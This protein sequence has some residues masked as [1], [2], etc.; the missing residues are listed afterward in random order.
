[1]YT[2]TK[3]S[4][5]RRRQ[6]TCRNDSIAGDSPVRP[7]R[8]FS[9]MSCLGFIGTHAGVALI[10]ITGFSWVALFSLFCVY[11][12]NM[13]GISAGFHR[14][15][16]HRSYKTNRFFQFVL[17]WLGTSAAQRG[18]LWWAAHHRDHHRHSDQK[19][20][21]HSPIRE[22][23]WYSHFGWILCPENFATKHSRVRDL[24]KYPELRF[25]DRFYLVPPF[26]RAS[27]LFG[28]GSF[29]ASNYPQL[30]T[31]GPQLLAWGFFAGTMISYHI[32]FSI[33]S[34]AHL[35]GSRSYE[36]SDSSKNN[37]LLALLTFGEGWHNNHHQYPGL[38]R[39]GHRWWEFDLTH[40]LLKILSSL[41]VVYDMRV[42]PP[43]D[44]LKYES[45]RNTA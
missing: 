28:L 35:F 10:F 43:I 20:D 6:D 30:Q 14:Y 32:T 31:S 33:N 17:A 15:F 8:R 13:F 37:W 5:K 40:S 12:L 26:V 4:S 36:T 1:M 27:I 11:A 29:L 25:L 16:S 22:A 9:P 3:S 2:T 23:F 7:G 18:P 24:T 44:K 41:G 34:F 21:I 38:E 45:T 42:Q 39:H 19:E